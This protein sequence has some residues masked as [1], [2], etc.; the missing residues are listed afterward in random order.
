VPKLDAR[1][2]VAIQ[3][4]NVNSGAFD[5]AEQIC[6]RPGKQAHGFTSM[7]RS[8]YGPLPRPRAHTL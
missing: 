5:P 6:A 8:G 7:E 1:T 2:L 3:A 4:G